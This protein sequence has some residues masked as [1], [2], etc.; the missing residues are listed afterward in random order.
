MPDIK[1]KVKGLTVPGPVFEVREYSLPLKAK[2]FEI[3]MPE[4][5][6]LLAVKPSPISID[7]ACLFAIVKPE[8]AGAIHPFEWYEANEPITASH[9]RLYIDSILTVTPAAPQGEHLHLFLLM[10]R[11]KRDS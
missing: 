7:E 9:Y 6:Q 3:F 10:D 11:I 5:S 1:T 4:N 2:K 8:N